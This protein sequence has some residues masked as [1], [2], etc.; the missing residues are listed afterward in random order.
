[1][2]DSLTHRG[3]DDAGVFQRGGVALAARRLKVLDLTDDAHMPMTDEN[4]AA[5]LVF[6][7]EIYNFR[8][9]RSQLEQRGHRFRSKGDSEVVLRAYLEWGE[10]CCSRLEGMFAFVIWDTRSERLFAARDRLGV[11]PFF[12]TQAGSRFAFASEVH[13]LYPSVSV[14][15]DS[16]DPLSLDFYLGFGYLPADRSFVSGIEKL[17]PGHYLCLDARGLRVTRYWELR[18]EPDA[19]IDEAAALE[20]WDE[21]FSDAVRRR[22]R[23]DV[24]LGCFLSGGI[25]SGLVTALAARESDVPIQTFSVG[26][27]GAEALDE[28]PLARQVA[29]RYGTRHTELYV[30]P[31]DR[32]ALPAILHNLG[33]PFADIGCLPMAQISKAASE[34]ITVALSGDGGDESFAGYAN[35]TAAWRA[36]RLRALSPRLAR[37][38]LA[39]VA[40]LPGIRGLPDA[41]RARRW[42]DGYVD[43]PLARQLGSSDRWTS[44]H[45]A[46]LYTPAWQQR[47]EPDGVDR[48]V[49]AFLPPPDERASLGDA[50][51]HLYADLGLRLPG[52]YLPKVDIASSACSLEVRSPFLDHRVVEWAGRLPL[53]VKRAGGRS[54]GLLRR[55]AEPLLPAALVEAPKRGFAP[56]VG[57]WLRGAW[58]PWAERLVDESRAVEAG[59]FE[60]EAVRRVADAHL[61]GRESHGQRLWSFMA[62]EIWWRVFITREDPL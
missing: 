11:K 60:A 35:V 49:E 18:F 30:D 34:H 15:A 33:E 41:Q 28:R 52:D 50:Q 17:P 1:M 19:S 8:E 55:Y 16:I 32:S 62:L 39:A 14:S 42:L 53:R 9:L 6:N 10:D 5:W 29:E 20:A 25:D 57:A 45:R 40:G 46:A 47:L 4:Q 51:Q 3:P 24:P 13:A 44:A 37:R 26:F 27:A 43:A 59:L 56:D 61:G 48:L 21:V 2:R 38:T 22:L 54:K 12:Y 31:G 36:E 23:S 7:G 58:A